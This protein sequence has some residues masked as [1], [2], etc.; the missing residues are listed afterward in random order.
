MLDPKDII[1]A[2][3]LNGALEV[4]AIDSETGQ[5][6]YTV[7]EKM[8]ELA[9]EIYEEINNQIYRDVMNLWQKGL[10]MVNIMSDSP[11]VSP[12]EHGLDR[13]NWTNLSDSE[14]STMNT[15]MRLFEGGI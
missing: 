15:V 4:S 9:P 5:F 2:L 11:E 8:A 1:D 12:S 14:Y 3:I 10:L 13:A 7:T 6:V